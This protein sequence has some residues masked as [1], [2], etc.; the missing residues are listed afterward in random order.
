MQPAHPDTRRFFQ[1]LR[2]GAKCFSPSLWI[3]AV[4]VGNGEFAKRTARRAAAVLVLAPAG[5]R[6]RTMAGNLR[7]RY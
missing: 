2:R 6:R 7:E 4:T 3:G 5:A 1:F